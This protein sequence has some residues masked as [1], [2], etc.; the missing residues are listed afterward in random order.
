MTEVDGARVLVFLGTLFGQTSPVTMFSDLVG[1]EVTLRPGLADLRSIRPTST[2]CSA[3]PAP[4]GGRRVA[5]PGEIVFQPRAPAI[6]LE[7]GPVGAHAVLVLGGAP[8]GEQI[9]MWWN[10]IGRS[11]D[12]VVGF[13]EDWQR[14][15]A[16]RRPARPARY[17]TFP[18]AWGHTL[19]APGLPNLRLRSRG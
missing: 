8:F 19:P 4:D 17:G 1:A 2:G 10:F 6:T 9:V 16:R 5:K 14:E 12:E 15:R 18:E 7:A 3:T 13:R 11:H